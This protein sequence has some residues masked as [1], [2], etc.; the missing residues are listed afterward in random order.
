M[1]Y[2]PSFG[3]VF[4]GPVGVGAEL[5]LVYRTHEGREVEEAESAIIQACQVFAGKRGLS[6][7][8]IVQFDL[9]THAEGADTLCRL[10]AGMHAEGISAGAA[11]GRWVDTFTPD[12][13]DVMIKL[14][15]S[16]VLPYRDLGEWTL[17][18]NIGRGKDA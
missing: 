15:E 8:C 10:L 6:T 9:S 5:A 16:Q 2:Q 7:V 18:K 11:I 14:V 3:A 13:A 12:D 17:T 1:T 4:I